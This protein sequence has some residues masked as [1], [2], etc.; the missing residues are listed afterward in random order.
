MCR[1]AIALASLLRFEAP[2]VLTQTM[3]LQVLDCA[4]LADHA[5]NGFGT[6]HANPHLGNTSSSFGHD[7]YASGISGSSPPRNEFG[8]GGT[9]AHT[10]SHRRDRERGAEWAP[11]AAGSATVEVHQRAGSL[12]R[13][14]DS[15]SARSA[16]GSRRGVRVL[17]ESGPRSLREHTGQQRRPSSNGANG[18]DDTGSSRS[19]YGGDWASQR[20][21]TS[22]RSIQSQRSAYTP[23]HDPLSP[24]LAYTAPAPAAKVPDVVFASVDSSGRG[25]HSLHAVTGAHSSRGAALPPPRPALAAD[26]AHFAGPY[27]YAPQ[28]PVAT[29]ESEEHATDGLTVCTAHLTAGVDRTMAADTRRGRLDTAL[30][31]LAASGELFLGKYIITKEMPKPGSQAVVAFARGGEGGYFQYAIKYAARFVCVLCPGAATNSQ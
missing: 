30:Q 14:L 9:W 8:L 1:C 3:W 2:A 13:P 4:L 23:E 7:R 31:N 10:H 6:V 24:G 5:N 19:D 26:T 29:I 12:Q 17:A 27:A 15:A 20:R 18:N 25:G 16:N 22:L 21:P 11:P 28:P